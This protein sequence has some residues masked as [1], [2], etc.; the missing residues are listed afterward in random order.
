MTSFEQ[1]SQDIEELLVAKSK[2]EYLL[3]RIDKAIKECFRD[4]G[5]H[6][7]QVKIAKSS[8][9]CITAVSEI[10]FDTLVK[11]REYFRGYSMTL[12]FFNTNFELVFKKV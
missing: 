3:D 12:K 1:F 5:L 9:S 2:E 8:F 4:A 11:I 10:D 6:C 7:K